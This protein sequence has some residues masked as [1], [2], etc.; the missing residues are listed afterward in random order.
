MMGFAAL[1]PSYKVLDVA[2]EQL[3]RHAFGPADEAD[4]RA[5]PHRGRLAGELDALGLQIGGD[6]VDAAHRKPEMIE[7]AI[8]RRRRGI[9]AVTGF[10]RGD[11]D[12]GAAELE[13]D[14]RLALLHGA[15]HLGAELLLEPLRHRLGIGGAQVDV[16]PRVFRHGA[17]APC[18]LLCVAAV[19]QIT[20][21]DD[22][23]SSGFLAGHHPL[24]EVKE[25]S[26]RP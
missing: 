25:V 21:D 5:G 15:D 11:E 23:V 7:A 18:Y 22:A 26:R 2:I 17:Y 9:D 3:D 16:V 12:V 8:R 19:M 4:A 24:R 10:D 1:Y 14:A 6:G 13:I 20:I